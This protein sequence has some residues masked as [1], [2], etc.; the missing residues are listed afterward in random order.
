MTQPRPTTSLDRL[1]RS[2]SAEFRGWRQFDREGI[3]PVKDETRLAGPKP[4]DGLRS[5]LE[6]SAK[7]PVEPREQ[8]SPL[9]TAN[10]PRA[11]IYQPWLFRPCG[12]APGGWRSPRPGGLAGTLAQS[13]KRGRIFIRPR[14]IILS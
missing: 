11:K 7:A 5:V 4:F 1:L 6:T 13:K 8:P 2:S 3:F 9:S 14:A 10:L 12:K